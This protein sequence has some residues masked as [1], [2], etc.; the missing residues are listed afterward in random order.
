MWNEPFQR[1]A[2]PLS[3]SPFLT[4]Q[5][6]QNLLSCSHRH[7]LWFP[8]LPISFSQTPVGAHIHTTKPSPV[9]VPEVLVYPPAFIWIDSYFIVAFLKKSSFEFVMVIGVNIYV[10]FGGEKGLLLATPPPKPFQCSP[11]CYSNG[12]VSGAS[13]ASF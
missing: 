9:F 5:H 12:V 13:S 6:V 7:R 11:L 2:V 4:G 3:Q 8:F 1:K 10:Y